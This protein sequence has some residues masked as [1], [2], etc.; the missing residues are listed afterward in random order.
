MGAFRTHAVEFPE[1]IDLFFSFLGVIFK[2]SERK[3]RYFSDFDLL[4]AFVAN[5]NRW[6]GY[7]AR[8]IETGL[9]PSLHEKFH[10]LRMKNRHFRSRRC[11]LLTVTQV[12]LRFAF[13]RGSAP[14]PAAT[15]AIPQ[16]CPAC[17]PLTPDGVLIKRVRGC[18]GPFA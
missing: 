5:G 1:R 4:E 16:S 18:L 15:G 17:P 7:H 11:W 10:R 3:R 14:N 13:I 6:P 2:K 9:F 12:G 8:G